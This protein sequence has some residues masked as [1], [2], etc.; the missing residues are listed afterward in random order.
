MA[1]R[2][3]A[4]DLLTLVGAGF[5][6]DPYAVDGSHFRW[7]VS[8]E[9]G[10]PREPFVLYVRSSAGA[11]RDVGY[12]PLGQSL[13]QS[14]IRSF[15]RTMDD[16]NYDQCRIYRASG[17]GITF[18]GAGGPELSSESLVID[19]RQGYQRRPQVTPSA[20]MVVLEVTL[21]PGEDVYAAAQTY[22][23]D[24]YRLVDEDYGLYLTTMNWSPMLS[25]PG[26]ETFQL[27]LRG[28]HI[29][30]LK[31]RGAGTV[32]GCSWVETGDYVT[33]GNWDRI[34]T[35]P[36]PV[37]DPTGRWYRDPAW[38]I[39]YDSAYERLLEG[40]SRAFPPWE[41]RDIPPAAGAPRPEPWQYEERY[42]RAFEER[43]LPR[44][45]R[46]LMVSFREAMPQ[47]ELSELVTLPNPVGSGG[48]RLTAGSTQA[49]VPLLSSLF[50]EGM[51][52]HVARLLGLGVV[53]QA[54]DNECDFK[55]EARYTPDDLERNRNWEL[56]DLLDLAGETEL[57]VVSFVPGLRR[58]QRDLP[59]RPEDL[60]ARLDGRATADGA[61]AHV[62][63]G[64]ESPRPET[65]AAQ[66]EVPLAYALAREGPDGFVDLNPYDQLHE[67]FLPLLPAFD[68]DGRAV[69]H[70]LKLPQEGKYR[71]FL[72][73]SDM[74]DRWSP[75]SD[76]VFTYEDDQLPL[77]PGN[78]KAAFIVRN[79]KD[80]QRFLEEDYEEEDEVMWAMDEAVE[81]AEDRGQALR[82]SFEWTDDHANQSP[83]VQ[84]FS[85]RVRKGSID[86]DAQGTWRELSQWSGIEA[87]KPPTTR[88]DP[89]FVER[90]GQAAPTLT[91]GNLTSGS[92]KL[93]SANTFQRKM[94]DGSKLQG[95]RYV[96]DLAGFNLPTPSVD[97]QRQY[98]SVGVVAHSRRS[99]KELISPVSQPGVALLLYQDRPEPVELPGLAWSSYP[100]ATGRSQYE[101][102]WTRETGVS[103]AVYRTDE[104][105]L[106]A[107]AGERPDQETKDLIETFAG[108]DDNLRLQA[109]TLRELAAHPGTRRAFERLNDVP[110]PGPD[111]EVS[112]VTYADALPGYAQVRFIYCLLGLSPTGVEAHWPSE[113]DAFAVVHVPLY[114]VPG[115]PRWERI[116]QGDD[117]VRL[118]FNIEG[119]R[120]DENGAL[121][122]D[123]PDAIEIYRCINRQRVT[124]VRHM[125]YLGA[126]EKAS[127]KAEDRTAVY[128]DEDA[129]PW[130]RYHY[131]AVA[132]GPAVERPLADGSVAKQPAARSEASQAMTAVTYDP[133]PPAKAKHLKVSRTNEGRALTWLAEVEDETPLGPFTIGVWR[134]WE[135]SAWEQAAFGPA[136]KWHQASSKQF[137]VVDEEKLPAGVTSVAY[138]IRIVDPLQRF[139]DS[140]PISA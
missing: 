22:T 130:R 31:V 10:L 104:N 133:D 37:Q 54:G 109:K 34:K 38:D 108:A 43:L 66:A 27:M 111:S 47:K 55:L 41:Q 29:H 105:A 112:E 28:E 132:R 85:V 116:E 120:Y 25:Q 114:V 4:P 48:A 3:V 74:W 139:S 12:H 40:R 81:W 49:E 87:Q 102:N 86:L 60:Q 138:R 96:L 119:G 135:D 92:A 73:A 1:L 26:P 15:T 107:A 110:I 7:F 103:Y 13:H 76:T 8:P 93:V 18:A 106:L 125:R 128:L 20:A 65:P 19:L 69:C 44:L 82:I 67:I 17:Q 35:I 123:M 36:L 70:D 14:F 5:D 97:R 122:Q 61:V 62:R 23:R 95:R 64:W 52:Y 126:I 33:N 137:K 46:L 99:G 89:L 136:G 94:P 140:D 53:A 16:V 63:L 77:P 78:V 75:W 39:A 118:T 90:H 121:S 84:A 6:Q 127:V 98:L 115:I 129:K 42:L 24:G 11:W 101:L 131:R 134:R 124:H 83:P 32:E 80:F 91:T 68:K 58:K 57:L 59:A 45:E 79:D 100:D 72:S 2:L 113:P 88:R 21:E 71:Y 9:L 117:G 50:L 51:D 56:L 30:R